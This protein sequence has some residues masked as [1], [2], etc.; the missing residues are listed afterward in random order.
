MARSWLH[1]STFYG[2]W[3]PGDPR[4]SVTR[5]RDRRPED[6]DCIVRLE[7]D[8]PGT[9]CDADLPGLWR[10]ALAQMKGPRVRIDLSQSFA[11]TEQFQETALYRSWLLHATAVMSNHVHIVVT[12]PD[13][14]DPADVL[15]EFK[16]YGSRRLNR[17]WGK[18]PNGTWWTESGSKRKL[19][20][21]R[22]VADA[23]AYVL[24]QQFPLVVWPTL[25]GEPIPEGERGA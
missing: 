2:N 21:E 25:Q 6:G 14:P 8:I 23:I 12:V 22:A 1:T 18:R 19:G 24:G 17:K 10:A 9:P 3:L 15:G 4:G 20:D 7:H 11:L 16:G 5:V 13:D